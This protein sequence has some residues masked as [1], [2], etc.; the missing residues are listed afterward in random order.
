MGGGEGWGVGVKG[1]RRQIIQYWKRGRF[2]AVVLFGFQAS[3]LQAI[4]YSMS[5]IHDLTSFCVDCHMQADGRWGCSLLKGLGSQDRIQIFRTS[6]FWPHVRARAL[7]AP[8]F[9][10]SSPSQTG[11]A[12]PPPNM[13]KKGFIFMLAKHIQAILRG[14]SRGPSLFLPIWGQNYVQVRPYALNLRVLS[15]LLFYLFLLLFSSFICLYFFISL[16][17]LFLS[18][19]I[20]LVLFFLFLFFSSYI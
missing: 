7:R 5:M 14:F 11:A 19:H 12:P 9:L 3:L 20:L 17:L 10:G 2:F 18:L 16:I 6:W 4:R 1:G 8:V 15:F 13:R